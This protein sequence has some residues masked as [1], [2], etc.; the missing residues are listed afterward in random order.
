MGRRPTSIASIILII[1]SSKFLSSHLPSFPTFSPS[2]LLS[3]NFPHSAFRI[4]HSTFKLCVHP[5]SSIFPRPS[6]ILHLLTFPTS[7][8]LNFFPLIFRIPHSQFRLPL[9]LIFST[10]FR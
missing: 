9:P 6:S 5:P 7:H 3:V 2:Q 8:L 10:S 1:Q 4:P